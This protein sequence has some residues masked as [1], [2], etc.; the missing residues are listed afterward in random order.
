MERDDSLD[1]PD[2]LRGR[3]EV[4]DRIET[5]FPRVFDCVAEHTDLDR[6]AIAL[7]ARLETVNRRV[8]DVLRDTLQAGHGGERL[9]RLA[10]PHG[11]IDTE[12]YDHLD[13]LLAGVLPFAPPDDVG[14]TPP[15]M[16]FYQPTPA[17]HVFDLIRRTAPCADDVVVDLGSG[18]G[19]VPLMIALCTPARAVG[20]ER[21]T[22]Y[23]TR[24]RQ[25]AAALNLDRIQ[26]IRQDARDADFST[27]TLF[28]LYTPFSGSILRC[29]LDALQGEANHR[30][31][32][33]CAYGPCGDVI[34]R[35]TWLEPMEPPKTNRVAI[36]RSRDGK[37]R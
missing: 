7:R 15:E 8:H 23:F 6:R 19:H 31:I 34:A 20:I 36:F 22:A 27:G 16:V 30:A 9:M 3:A 37:P 24:A 12:G 28:Y 5:C 33:V 1:D 2:R 25:C 32:R 13:D 35:E 14:E 10:M 18:L 11:P 21:E 17:R 29:V 4:L 26:F